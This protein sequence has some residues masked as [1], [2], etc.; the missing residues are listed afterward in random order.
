MT[1]RLARMLTAAGGRHLTPD[2]RRELL[3]YAESVPRRVEAAEAVEEAE[4]AVVAGAV[5]EL[6]R[7]Y[8]NF[9]RYHEQAWEK[10][11]RDLALAARY[12]VQATLADD[13]E[14]LD[15]QVLLWL[16]TVLAALNLTPGFVR[17][18]FTLL[19]DG[20]RAALPADAFDLLEP[21]LDRTVEVTSDFPEPA[22]P[23][24]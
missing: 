5:E 7:R 2:E 4:E 11:G 22:M 10:I 12:A 8:P 15:E 9:E 17:D 14:L 3:D 23:A 16:R 1:P 18:A 24:V 20:F 6:Q 13:A 19:R 21:A